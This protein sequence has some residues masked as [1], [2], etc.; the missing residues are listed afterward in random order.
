MRQL[1]S[2][3]V[4]LSFW[5]MNDQKQKPNAIIKMQTQTIFHS[6]Y[7]A[8]KTSRDRFKCGFDA[9]ISLYITYQDNLIH[10]REVHG[11][12]EILIYVIICVDRT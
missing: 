1:Q 6:Y 7:P 10:V 8:H 11:V 4:L 9:D 5:K 12:S 3:G 2:I